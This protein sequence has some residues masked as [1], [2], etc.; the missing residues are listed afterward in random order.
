MNVEIR[1]KEL[2][3]QGDAI[4]GWHTEVLGKRRQPVSVKREMRMGKKDGWTDKGEEP[5][6]HKG[7][8]QPTVTRNQR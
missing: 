7:N 2:A 8:E 3:R 4:A 6:T 5:K 1:R